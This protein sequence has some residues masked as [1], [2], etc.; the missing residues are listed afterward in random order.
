[1]H[2]FACITA[3]GLLSAAAHAAPELYIGTVY[4]YLEGAQ[5]SYRK[6]LTNSGD[7]TAFVRV[8]LAEI[9]YGEGEPKEIPLHHGS[10]GPRHGLIAT[11]S[12][13]I[14]P[15]NGTQATRLLYL[16]ERD[17]ER[18]Y[19]VR[20]V[21]VVPDKDDT[22]D[23]PQAERDAYKASFKAGVNVLTGYGAVFIVR[24]SKPRF[25]TRIEDTASHY[26]ITNAGNSTVVLDA[27]KSCTTA[28]EPVCEPS[29]IHHVMPGKTHQI[30]K[31]PGRTLHFN[32]VEG[33]SRHPTQI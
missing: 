8:S 2:K 11:P 12:R 7:S 21:P 25:D 17:R 13:L 1:M 33:A 6:R 3:L 22:F 9:I 10:N 28:E 19:R 24:P 31:T 18:Y 30:D 26:R 4:D 32:R 16:G 14:I 15:A 29:R 20:F 5:S 27:Y 23:L